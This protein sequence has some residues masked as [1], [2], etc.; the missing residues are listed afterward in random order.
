[1]KRKGLILQLAI[2]IDD[3]LG[4]DHALTVP[5]AKR[6]ITREFLAKRYRIRKNT[7]IEE[8]DWYFAIQAVR[9]DR[10]GHFNR[11]SRDDLTPIETR[12][13]KILD[14]PRSDWF[15]SSSTQSKPVQT[16]SPYV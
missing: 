4:F 3:I 13:T 15:Y 6:F 9:V 12:V 8:L 10:V 2:A 7:T 5:N 1:M 16:T 14:N 11:V